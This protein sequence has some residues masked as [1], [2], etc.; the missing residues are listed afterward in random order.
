MQLTMPQDH[1][2]D[3]T[4]AACD[5]HFHVFAAHERV[6]V[7]RYVPAYASSL[8]DWMLAARACSVTRGV[9]VQ[10][11]FLGTNNARMLAAIAQQPSLLRGVAVVA[12]DVTGDELHALY[13]AGV[14]GVRLNLA[15]VSNDLATLRD[16]STQWWSAL[17]D[18]RLHLELH[19]DV[20]R[21]A[22]LLPFVP[23]D[24]TV[25]LDHFAKPEK[26]AASD[27][28]VTTVRIRNASGASGASGE[29]N[30]A[31]FV[32]LSGAYRQSAANATHATDI[33]SLWRDEIGVGRLLWGSDWPCTNHESAAKYPALFNALSEWL[34][35]AAD[36]R[37]V[38]SDN[39]TVVYWR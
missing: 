35:N 6:A 2:V 27:E 14:R 36:M 18:A 21:A 32:T 1:V 38:L 29:A 25:V 24:M 28:T 11:S 31:T 34:P 7:A 23:R 22:A 9:I 20:G 15:G 16:I 30:A 12:S 37:A 39:P 5:C 13:A 33:A 17:I 4:P 3:L 8:D 19:T 10:P 26:I